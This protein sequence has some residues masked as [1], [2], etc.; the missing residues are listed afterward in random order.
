MCSTPYQKIP[1]NLIV[2][3]YKLIWDSSRTHN[4]LLLVLMTE[5]KLIWSAIYFSHLGHRIKLLLRVD[6]MSVSGLISNNQWVEY[7]DQIWV[8]RQVLKYEKW[9][10][11]S[12]PH[13]LKFRNVLFPTRRLGKI[14]AEY[15]LHPFSKN[16]V[17]P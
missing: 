9:S 3:I 1:K 6:Y 11:S 8:M 12:K 13:W 2:E 15:L 5:N 4:E 17:Y 7:I 10:E 16:I 14:N